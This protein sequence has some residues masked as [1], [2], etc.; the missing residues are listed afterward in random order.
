LIYGGNVDVLNF[1]V[2][3]A[4]SLS[5]ARTECFNGGREDITHTAA[6]TRKR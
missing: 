1:S 2:K 3:L 4:S 5:E 6:P